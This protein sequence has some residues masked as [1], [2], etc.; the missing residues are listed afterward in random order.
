MAL[1]RKEASEIC[2][3]ERD[4]NDCILHILNQTLVNG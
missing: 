2:M 4:S 3:K 1:I